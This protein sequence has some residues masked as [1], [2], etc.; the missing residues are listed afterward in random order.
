M[1][2]IAVSLS[3]L[4]RAIRGVRGSFSIT[5]HP[6]FRWRSAMFKADRSANRLAKAMA[7]EG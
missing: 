7:G 1:Q 6:R 5:R 4:P 2:P 3:W